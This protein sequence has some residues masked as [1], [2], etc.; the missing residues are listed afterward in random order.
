MR[1]TR[2]ISACRI[3]LSRQE[4]ILQCT[5]QD[6]LRTKLQS[7][8]PTTVRIANLQPKYP[9]PPT[10]ARYSSEPYL[11]Y[12]AMSC[13]GLRPSCCAACDS[14]GNHDSHHLPGSWKDQNLIAK[15]FLVCRRTCLVGCRARNSKPHAECPDSSADVPCLQACQ[16]TPGH[17]R[18]HRHVLPGSKTHPMTSVLPK[19]ASKCRPLKRI[20]LAHI[21]ALGGPMFCWPSCCTTPPK[22]VRKQ[23]VQ[24]IYTRLIGRI[25]FPER[26]KLQLSIRPKLYRQEVSYSRLVTEFAKSQTQKNTPH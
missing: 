9:S 19:Q 18:H 7:S 1:A 10:A 16:R 4:S 3:C 26:Q 21:M 15:A 23:D 25:E 13:P 11:F 2:H 12:A 6:A 20:A 17:V 14:R 5:S 22:L 24:Q 8:V